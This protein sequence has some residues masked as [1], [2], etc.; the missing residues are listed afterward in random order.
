MK[1]LKWCAFASATI[2]AILII[3]AV[4]DALFNL[5]LLGAAHIVSYFHIANCFL[6]V[7]IV[8][9]FYTKKCCECC[10]EEK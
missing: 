3:L 8:I 9:L 1:I 6:L 5:K 10:K 7:T 4:L 2:A